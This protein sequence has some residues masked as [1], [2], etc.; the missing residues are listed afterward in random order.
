MM[1]QMKRMS[2]FATASDGLQAKQ[3]TIVRM[4]RIL[5]FVAAGRSGRD[6]AVT[7]ESD[8]LHE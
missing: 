5:V 4:Q 6:R 3:R 8:L 1:T 7:C 2:T